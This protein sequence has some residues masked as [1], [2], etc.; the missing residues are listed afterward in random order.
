MKI[1][2]IG[3]LTLMMCFS[4]IGD[5]LINNE[6]PPN[7]RIL[8]SV[9]SIA[10]GETFQM[11]AMFTNNVGNV[12]DLALEWES[13][14]IEILT[15]SEDGLLTAIS[16]GEAIVIVSAEE[17][18]EVFKDSIM[19]IVGDVTVVTSSSRQGTLKT[20][21]S[22]ALDGSFEMKKEGT[23]LILSFSEDYNA[24]QNLP[25]LYIYLT[26][27]PSTINN[28]LEI[29][30]VQ[31]FSGAH[32]YVIPGNISLEEYNHVLYFCKPFTVKVGDGSF[33]N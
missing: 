12:V 13:S 17:N 5:D 25:G 26:N 30:K 32:Q 28:A 4:C 22:Y 6:V 2:F 21:S 18:G 9:D 8:S 24:S 31:V 20:T 11:Y 15:I 10:V 1:K 27:N 29:G 16:E 14:N 7:I 33:E 19:T 3:L 23:D